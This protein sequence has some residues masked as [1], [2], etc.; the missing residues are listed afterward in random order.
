MNINWE[1]LADS[2]VLG[3]CKVASE[4]NSYSRAMRL[5]L[6]NTNVSAEEIFFVFGPFLATGSG[7]LSLVYCKQKITTLIYFKSVRSCDIFSNIPSTVPLVFMNA[8]R[9]YHNKYICMRF[10][11]NR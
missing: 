5:P 4:V 11:C 2:N 8:G 3:E 7:S 1:E 9:I 6:Y 10:L